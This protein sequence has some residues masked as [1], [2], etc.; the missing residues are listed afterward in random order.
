[1]N[2]RVRP[3]SFPVQSFCVLYVA[4]LKRWCS[5]ADTWRP[6]IRVGHCD[7]WSA[8]Q[9]HHMLQFPMGCYCTTE[10]AS[11]EAIMTMILEPTGHRAAEVVRV[12]AIVSTIPEPMGRRAYGLREMFRFYAVVPPLR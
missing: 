6:T 1:V 12:K 3:T 5:T 9:N 8:W 10:V 2:L 11:P 7:V 4:I